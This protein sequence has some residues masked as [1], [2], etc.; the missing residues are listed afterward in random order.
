MSLRGEPM[1]RVAF[2]RLI[3]AGQ[4]AALL[5]THC[6][7]G[8]PA[9]YPLYSPTDHPRGP[10]DVARLIGYVRYVDGQDVSDH[11]SAFELLPGCHVVGTPSTWGN[12][13]ALSG[14]VV[15]TTGRVT[16][17][18]P[19][20]AGRQYE[21]RV[22]VEAPTGPT[23]TVRVESYETSARGEVTRRFSPASSADDI[24]RCHQEALGAATA[25]EPEVPKSQ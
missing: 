14:G 21:V 9:A 7:E 22:E 15:A 13:N 23:G 10:S 25:G 4:V 5:T 16:F 2:A 12:V 20:K 1:R 24:E 11:G 19:M 8:A 17:A 18:L 6:I 3:L